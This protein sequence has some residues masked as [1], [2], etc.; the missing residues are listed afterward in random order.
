MEYAGVKRADDSC[1]DLDEEQLDTNCKMNLRGSSILEEHFGLRE[2][3]DTLAQVYYGMDKQ[4][5]EKILHL[6]LNYER[7]TRLSSQYEKDID[8]LKAI[9]MQQKESMKLL[10]QR[11][12]SLVNNLEYYKKKLSEVE[13]K[14]PKQSLPLEEALIA[15]VNSLLN[16]K[17]RYKLLSEENKADAV[18]KVV[19]NNNFLKELH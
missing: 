3:F 12:H 7:E 2:A 19:F 14:Q 13:S 5:Q 16:L 9:A 8:D 1:S 10:R 4:C 11:V 18:A 15:T 17:E 6:Q